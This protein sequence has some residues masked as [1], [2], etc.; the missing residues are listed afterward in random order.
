VQEEVSAPWA[1]AEAHLVCA[2]LQEASWLQFTQHTTPVSESASQKEVIS[3]RAGL[4]RLVMFKPCSSEPCSYFL[5]I[6][7]V[8][9]EISLII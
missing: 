1:L 9:E 6:Q 5:G 8:G 7:G 3:R 4:L 2:H